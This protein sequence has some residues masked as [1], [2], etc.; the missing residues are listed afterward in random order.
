MRKAHEAKVNELRV[1]R[2]QW[3]EVVV[4]PV[5]KLLIPGDVR[6]ASKDVDV[7]L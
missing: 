4:E 3:Q 6:K 7:D 2:E 5:R 1:R